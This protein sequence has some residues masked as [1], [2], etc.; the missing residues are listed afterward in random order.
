MGNRNTTTKNRRYDRAHQ[1]QRQQ[2][3]PI[4]ATGTVNCWRCNQPITPDDDWD[5]GHR[6]GLPSAPEHANQCNRSDGGQR[7]P[8]PWWH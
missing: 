3:E 1:H 2:L 6:S 7:N 5:L 4:V 8:P